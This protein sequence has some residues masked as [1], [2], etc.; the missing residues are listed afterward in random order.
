[1]AKQLVM[2]QGPGTGLFVHAPGPK[3]SR[4]A[5]KAEKSMAEQEEV[6]EI[7]VSGWFLDV[8]PPFFMHFHG[9]FMV[10]PWIFTSFLAF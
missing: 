10:L 6:S 9:F 2:A 4:E 3:R 1:M 7:D 5:P 8:F